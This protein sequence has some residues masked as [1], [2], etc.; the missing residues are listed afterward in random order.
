MNQTYKSIWCERTNNYINSNSQ[1]I[2]IV[3]VCQSSL[4]T[5]CDS[6]EALGFHL[7]TAQNNVKGYECAAT[8]CPNLIVLDFNMTESRNR[9]ELF[10]ILRSSLLTKYIPI[11]ILCK[12][13]E[14]QTRLHAL[15]HGASDFIYGQY[16]IEEVVARMNIHLAYARQKV[17]QTLPLHKENRE[18]TIN[19][20]KLY[21]SEHLNDPPTL[22]QLASEL[23]VHKKKLARV[24]QAHMHETIYDYLSRL[25][26]DY[27]Q[28]LLRETQLSIT[29]IAEEIGFTSLSAFTSSFSK[30]YGM[31]PT[32]YRKTMS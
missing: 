26:L 23:G 32:A 19:R 22:D 11:I 7:S 17:H 29:D 2:L 15:Q 5:L 6:L 31:P 30:Q 28:V 24:F 9:F 4:S 27:S 21:L 10:D 20:I 1:H 14:L 8:Q 25:R 12:S 18:A 3:S 13:S 16:T